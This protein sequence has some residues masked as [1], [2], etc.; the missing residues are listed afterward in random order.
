MAPLPVGWSNREKYVE[1]WQ[2]RY[3]QALEERRRVVERAA[4][5]TKALEGI[6]ALLRTIP[7]D[8]VDGSRPR[9]GLNREAR[10]D[11]LLAAQ[12]ALVTEA[13]EGLEW[14]A[15]CHDGKLPSVDEILV[16]DAMTYLHDDELGRVFY[17]GQE[18]PRAMKNAS[19]LRERALETMKRLVLFNDDAKWR[20][21]NFSKR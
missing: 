2:R 13:V 12:S 14:E 17:R 6:D 1:Y 8:P 11:L 20:S 4:A 21:S 5:R 7:A 9:G 19:R 18:R 16:L 10:E 15:L 3:A